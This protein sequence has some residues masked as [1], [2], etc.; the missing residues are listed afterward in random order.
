MDEDLAQQDATS[1]FEVRFMDK[2]CAALFF[3]IEALFI[4]SP[5]ITPVFAK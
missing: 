1:L 4:V 3:H 5:G 2:I